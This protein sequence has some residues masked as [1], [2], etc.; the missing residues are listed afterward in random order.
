MLFPLSLLYRHVCQ[1]I[2]LP[3]TDSVVKQHIFQRIYD[4]FQDKQ[5]FI[6]ILIHTHTHTHT[7][8][9]S[10][11]FSL[12]IHEKPAYL[13]YRRNENSYWLM[14]YSKLGYAWFL[15]MILNTGFGI[16]QFCRQPERNRPL[17]NSPENHIPSRVFFLFVFTLPGGEMNC[18]KL[19]ATYKSNSCC[20]SQVM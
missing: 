17:V 1:I 11:L 18:C 4:P 12:T 10:F 7:H 2:Q 3:T 9:L 16:K 13:D 5:F 8:T 15:L 20:I 19:A 6:H 14:K